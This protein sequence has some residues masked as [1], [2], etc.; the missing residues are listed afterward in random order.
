MQQNG[1]NADQVIQV[2]G[3]ADQQLRKR[4]N[5]EDPSNRRI[6]VIVQYMVKNAD[7]AERAKGPESKTGEPPNGAEAPKS[8]QGSQA[9][10]TRV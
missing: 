4:D 6:S 7:G 3:Y 8:G 5:P 9:A 1:V 10:S 2:R